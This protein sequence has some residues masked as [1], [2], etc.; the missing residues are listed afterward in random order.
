[1]LARG[2]YCLCFQVTQCF[3]PLVFSDSDPLCCQMLVFMVLNRVAIFKPVEDFKAKVALRMK[4]L[5]IVSA[6]CTRI[7]KD[8]YEE[9]KSFQ[10]G[11][12]TELLNGIVANSTMN[13][14]EKRKKLKQVRPNVFDP[15]RLPL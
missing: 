4:S 14:K 3:A 6:F 8:E 1:M 7:T 15:L 11:H 5:G 12:M 9:Q 2:E 13:I 10:D